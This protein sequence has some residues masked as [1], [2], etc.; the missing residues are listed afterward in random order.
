MCKSERRKSE[1]N[2][3]TLDICCPQISPHLPVFELKLHASDVHVLCLT[4]DGDE[5][6][7]CQVGHLSSVQAFSLWL[8]EH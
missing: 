4:C 5:H 7:R 3:F 6:E 2:N 1:E 8:R